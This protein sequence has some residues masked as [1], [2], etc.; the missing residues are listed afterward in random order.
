MHY[1]L[2]S[3][4]LHS[5]KTFLSF[6][7]IT[8]TDTTIHDFED[9]VTRVLNANPLPAPLQDGWIMHHSRS[10]PGYCYYF[11]QFTGECK[12]DPPFIAPELSQ[13]EGLKETLA[14]LKREAT[15]TDDGNKINASAEAAGSRSILK[16]TDPPISSQD[17]PIENAHNQNNESSSPSN[18]KSHKRPH[19]ESRSNSEVSKK[20]KA[21]REV[22]VLHILKK[23]RD[24]RRPSSWR[25]K[26]I[27][28]S[29]EDA[30]AKLREIIAIFDE[31]KDDPKELRATFEELA[32][33]ESDCTSYKR[34]GDLGFFDRK[35]MQPSFSAASFALEVGEISDVVESSSGVHIIL[36]LA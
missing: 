17:N 34:G 28:I 9:S 32:K 5:H 8:M 22:R 3:H 16:M 19:V 4:A 25:Q 26:Q 24:S 36:R 13:L 33:E 27:T 15:L 12:W 31:I 30:I 7:K 21:P 2:L 35:K 6:I 29:K 1:S 20:S 14:S 10:Q 23:H 18:K 11:N